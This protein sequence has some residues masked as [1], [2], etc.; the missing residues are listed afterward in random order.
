MKVENI[1]KGNKSVVYPF[2]IAFLVGYLT[3]GR[4]FSQQFVDSAFPLGVFSVQSIDDDLAN[5]MSFYDFD[6]DGFDDLTM[7]AGTDSIVMY[8]NWNGVFQEVN[9]LSVAS[10]NVRQVLWV[11]YDNDSDLDLF[12]SYYNIGVRLYENDGSF[13]FSDVTQQ[14]G[15]T[16]QPFRSYGVAFAD[17]DGDF[18]LDIYICAY[19]LNSAS[20]NAVVNFYYQNDGSNYFSNVSSSLGIDN[21]FQPTFMPVWYDVELDGDVDLHL[22]NDREYTS[23][24]LYINNGIGQFT[25]QA[26]ILGISNDDHSP[27]SCS[28]G[29]FN[30]DGYFDVF[31]S[32]VANGGIENG[33]PTDY[34]IFQ[35]NSGTGFTNV[36]PTLGVD[37][38]FFA[39]GG[40]W[41]DYDN[42]CFEDLYVATA[43]N[44]MSV[45]SEKP[46]VF[47]KNNAGL[48]FS[49]ANDSIVGNITK[50][51]YSPVK[52]DINNDGFYDIV[53]LNGGNQPHNVLLN[54]GGSNNYIKITPKGTISNSFALGGRVEVF[55]NGQHQSKMI[56]SSDG[57]CAQ[58]SQHLIFGIGAAS[59]VDS[60]W[61]TFP[62]GLVSK[63]YNIAANQS[64][65][66]QEMASVQ[67]NLGNSS[68][69]ACPGDTFLLDYPGLTNY[70]WQDGSSNAFYEVTESGIYS[71]IAENSAGD[72]AYIS[73]SVIFEYEPI[74]TISNFVTDNPC[75]L[76]SLG[77]IALFCTPSQLFNTIVWSNGEQ[78]MQIDSL[79]SG[80]YSYQLTTNFGCVYDGSAT[81]LQEPSLNVS[82]IIAP[83]TDTSWGSAEFFVW[84]GVPP[85][86][87]YLD[88]VAIGSALYGMPPGVYSVE[89]V[90]ANG[91]SEIIEVV[92]PDLSTASIQTNPDIQVSVISEENQVLV[93]GENIH[94]LGVKVYDLTGKEMPIYGLEISENQMRFQLNVAS[95]VY[96][97][98]TKKGTSL[99]VIHRH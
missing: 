94:Q 82:H 56:V 12:L 96:Q 66:I 36:A 17:P 6:Q 43:E 76:D 23:D 11:D 10:G 18:D 71:F 2:L 3:A 93:K 97:V 50:A 64:I 62:S 47:Y 52:G 77:M 98:Y 1:L 14:V 65:A 73:T 34:K 33:L 61:V 38:N 4:A 37:T 49:F 30:N 16:T 28:L 89:L 40:L 5:G 19:T 42:D 88:T 92:I 53:V 70:E 20:P 8:K 91:C 67:V 60:I 29:D 27:M 15:I 72:T 81:V 75:G 63:E 74:P 21:G 90:D 58:N 86:T 45:L 35:N 26:A 46:S 22:I 31:E 83:Y 69:Q 99:I 48:D 51:S 9:F 7:P 39:W 25:N 79:A 44:T 80:M 87:Y 41:V 13:N 54:Q 57:L 84:G 95:G 78:T 32:D 85:Y 24:A 59:I 55:A 68:V